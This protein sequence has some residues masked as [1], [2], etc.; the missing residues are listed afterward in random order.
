VS[1]YPLASIRERAV[2]RIAVGIYR[3]GVF[4]GVT[5]G[6]TVDVVVD[7]F[8]GVDAL[9][10]EGKKNL[11]TDIGTDVGVRVG[12]GVGVGGATLNFWMRW[13]LASAT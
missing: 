3:V 10:I 12:V 7:V 9:M 5:V 1:L 2:L 8:V 4:V 11:H 13:L 6:V